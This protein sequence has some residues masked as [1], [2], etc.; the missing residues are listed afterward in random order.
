MVGAERTFTEQARREQLVT[1]AIATISEVGYA[2]ASLAK[3]AE[4][5]HVSK[6]V[7]LYHFGSKDELIAAVCDHIY[8]QL[9]QEMG[10]VFDRVE[11]YRDTVADYIR[12]LLQYY[13]RH[14]EQIR[15]VEEVVQRRPT[16][17]A[18]LADAADATARWRALATLLESGQASGELGSFDALAMGVAISGAIE[19]TL[20]LLRSEPDRDAELAI[21]QL[22]SLF[23]AAIKHP[24]ADRGDH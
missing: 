23:D 14:P 15:V 7:I 19:A 21:R 4:R 2:K 18:E 12:G 22:V 11:G 17:G 9:S 16:Q 13:L 1:Q 10:P 3:I 8:D 24:E 20:A 5:S 6:G